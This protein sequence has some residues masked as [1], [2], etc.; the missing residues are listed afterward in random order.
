MNKLTHSS[1]VISAGAF[2]TSC[3]P[4]LLPPYFSAFTKAC[5]HSR[6]MALCGNTEFSMWIFCL[7]TGSVSITWAQVWAQQELSLPSS[8]GFLPS[9]TTCY[10]S[11]PPLPE[12][13]HSCLQGCSQQIISCSCWSL[14]QKYLL[15]MLRW[16]SVVQ[17]RFNHLFLSQPNMVTEV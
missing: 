14:K 13:P 5:I 15:L 7:C 17:L 10:L 6:L 12:Q 2:L 3:T 1:E 11:T 16:L 8:C 4:L 9:P